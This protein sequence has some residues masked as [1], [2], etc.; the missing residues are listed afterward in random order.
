MENL[1]LYGLGA[2]AY[3]GIMAWSAKSIYV[4]YRYRKAIN[5]LAKTLMKDVSC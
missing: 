3:I 2:I 5:T 1:C 4:Y